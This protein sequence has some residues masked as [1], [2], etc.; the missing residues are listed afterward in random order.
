V[1]RGH[2][3]EAGEYDVTIKDGR[4]DATVGTMAHVI[5]DGQNEVIDRRAIVFSG[6]KKDKAKDDKAD[7]AK[8]T[9]DSDK[10][11]ELSP[12]DPDYWK[13]G[14]KSDDDAKNEEVEQKRGCGCRVGAHST[15][16][17]AA[18]LALAA[19]A[20]LV[21]RRRRLPAVRAAR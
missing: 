6:E 20:L 18:L 2:G 19:T 5:F 12:D 17:D 3:Y 9:D 4:T 7:D 15:G 21:R 14:P 11:K 8:K 1:T 13:G 10:K 16:E